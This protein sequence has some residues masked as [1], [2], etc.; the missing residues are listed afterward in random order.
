MSDRGKPRE[1][2]D[3]PDLTEQPKP[4]YWCMACPL[5]FTDGPSANAHHFATG[6]NQTFRESGSFANREARAANDV[7]PTFGKPQT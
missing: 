7:G 4:R 6:H 2:A 3:Y 5:T 1:A